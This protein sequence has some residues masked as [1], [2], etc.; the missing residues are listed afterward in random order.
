MSVVEQTRTNYR[1]S[2]DNKLIFMQ[3]NGQLSVRHIASFIHEVSTAENYDP[4]FNSIVDIRGLKT[5][6]SAFDAQELI[7]LSSLIMG[8]ASA[9]S[10]VVTDGYFKEKL[11]NVANWLCKRKNIEIKG[12]TNMKDACRWLDFDEKVPGF[13]L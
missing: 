3:I 8:E 7:E 4:L 12:F 6:I 1:I 11:V 9:K 2:S 10:A 5:T 13:N